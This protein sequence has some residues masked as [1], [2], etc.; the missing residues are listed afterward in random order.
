MRLKLCNVRNSAHMVAMR[1]RPKDVVADVRNE[2]RECYLA[3]DTLFFRRKK[4]GLSNSLFR[5]LEAA[6]QKYLTPRQWRQY[7]PD[8]S[9]SGR[10]GVKNFYHNERDPLSTGARRERAEQ[11]LLFDL[12]KCANTAT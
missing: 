5:A 9:Y 12:V 3:D 1:F 10:A 11:Q 4:D 8:F 6:R 2:I 7:R